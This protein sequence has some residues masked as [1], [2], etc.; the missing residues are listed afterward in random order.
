M[1]SYHGILVHVVFSTKYRSPVLAKSWRD[2]LYAYIGGTIKEHNATL[3]K[4]G[5][6]DDHVHLLI[7]LHPK[8]PISSTVQLLKSNSSKWINDNGKTSKKFQWQPGYGAFSVSVSQIDTVKAYFDNQEEHHRTKTYR[9]E[10]LQFL[11]RHRIEYD[12]EYVFEQDVLG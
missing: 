12:E 7:R 11:Q 2:D 9:E 6:V 10:F 5:G 3:I 4:S 1:S 8:F